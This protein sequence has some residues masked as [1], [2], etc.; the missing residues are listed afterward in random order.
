MGSSTQKTTTSTAPAN[1]DVSATLSKLA[2]G[3]S[4]EYTPGKSLYQPAGSTTQ[5]SWAA[6][7]EAANN[8]D[9][10]TGLAGALGSFGNRA[11]GAEIGMNAPG[12][13]AM[14]AAVGDDV[15]TS[16]NG[17]FN[18]SGLFGSDRNQEAAGRGL[19]EALGGLD[20]QNYRA[21]IGDQERAA[22]M[23]PQL[24]TA[25]QLPSAA[26]GAIGAAQDANQQGI[27]N[28]P[29]DYLAKMT[30]ILSKKSR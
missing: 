5:G 17:A 19:A 12:Y 8:P 30:S 29:T 6:G 16:T 18:S 23:L 2:K 1:K 4:A 22:T 9:Y 3:I 13:A 7:L 14:R 11:S 15:L 26:T 28:G 20:Y 25:G 10:A 21:S 27:A 24:F